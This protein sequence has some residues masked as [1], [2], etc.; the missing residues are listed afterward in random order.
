MNDCTGVA[1]QMVGMG[2]FAT[3]RMSRLK[4]HKG[5]PSIGADGQPTPHR[6]SCTDG[7]LM[8]QLRFTGWVICGGWLGAACGFFLLE[9]DQVR[10]R[11]E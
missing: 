7:E 2:L 5:A 11:L 9:I 10:S 3:L 8:T 1:T 4:L 6:Y